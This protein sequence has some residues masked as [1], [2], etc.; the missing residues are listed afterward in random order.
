LCGSHKTLGEVGEVGLVE[1]RTHLMAGL[2]GEGREHKG[3][4]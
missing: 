3:K 2:C 4:M 1:K